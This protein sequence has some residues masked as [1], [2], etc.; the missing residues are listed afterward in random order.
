M[1]N[2]EQITCDFCGTQCEIDAPTTYSDENGY[3]EWCQEC[4]DKFQAEADALTPTELADWLARQGGIHETREG[5]RIIEIL[6]SALT[7]QAEEVKVLREA[8]SGLVNLNENPP[9]DEPRRGVL[10][11]MAWTQARAALAQAGE[12]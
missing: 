1:T 8:L 6:R 5:E 2:I 4:E 9:P 7:A 10:A 12:G 3:W 11:N